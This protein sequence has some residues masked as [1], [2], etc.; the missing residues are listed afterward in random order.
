MAT[1]YYNTDGS[2]HSINN[3]GPDVAF[4]GSIQLQS[5]KASDLRKFAGIIYA[6]AS[7]TGLVQQINPA[8]PDRE[9][10]RETF[11]IALSM[12]NYV[13]AKKRKGS[14]FN[15]FK[16]INPATG[17]NY[18]HGIVSR[19]FGEFVNG[20]PKDHKRANAAI[21]ASMRLLLGPQYQQDMQ[22]IVRGLQGSVWWD[23]NDLFRRYKE[24]YRA[25]QGF[26]LSNPA[27]GAIYQNTNIKGAQII[28]DCVASNPK[29]LSTGRQ[30][31]FLSTMALAGSIFFKLHPQAEAQGVGV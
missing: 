7:Y 27:H 25:K 12:F 20:D 21:M 30:Y 23:G 8:N 14:D 18:V 13:Q 31:T 17:K 24:H 22:D 1:V 28:S 5:V 4:I 10:Q 19:D 2:I 26:Q 16:L 11:A 3:G 6:E 29:V 15:F 9:M